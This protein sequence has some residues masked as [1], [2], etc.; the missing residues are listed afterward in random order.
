MFECLPNFGST[1]IDSILDIRSELA[2]Y[3][4][5]FRGGIRNYSTK[6]QSVSWSKD[7]APEAVE[8]FIG[9]VKPAFLALEDAIKSNRSIIREMTLLASGRWD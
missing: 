3:L 4:D 2:K 7:F 6:I 1:S 5:P 8:I 9:D